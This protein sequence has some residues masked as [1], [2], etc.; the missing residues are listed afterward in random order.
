MK[1]TTVAIMFA[2][3]FLLMAGLAYA[4]GLHATG[5]AGDLKVRVSTGKTPAAGKNVLSIRLSDRT[6]KPVADALVRVFWMMPSMGAMPAMKGFADAARSGSQY[7]AVMDLE[8]SGTWHV[9][10]KVK[11]AGKL[12]PPMKFDINA[13]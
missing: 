5:Q 1:K 12:L 9:M 11:R 3:A 13:E 4:G 8:T 2:A 6:G 10:V 7:H